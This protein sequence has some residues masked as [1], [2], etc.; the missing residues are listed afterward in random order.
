MKNFLNRYTVNESRPLDQATLHILS[1]V[2]RLA[3]DLE[4]PYIVVGAT[5]RDLLLFHVFGIPVTRA[6]ADVDFAI[7]VD[8]WERF[9][10]L[11]T[12]LLTSGLYG[13]K[14]RTSHLPEGAFGD[15]RDSRRPDSFRRGI[16]GRC[17]PL[18]SGPGNGN[19][20]RRI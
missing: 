10:G 20:S 14:D 9:R 7:A 15:R 11:R 8:S 19:D 13:R 18:A 16:S 2:N 3:G 1:V 12:A 6:T 17:D 4:L 5:A